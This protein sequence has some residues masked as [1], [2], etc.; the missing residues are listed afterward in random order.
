MEYNEWWISDFE[1]WWLWMGM[2][3]VFLIAEIL[4][5]GFFL[6]WFSF[7]AAAAGILA[8]MGIGPAAQIIIFVVTTGILFVFGR[9]FAESVTHQQPPGIGAD[10]FLEKE[11]L[12]IEDI[13]NHNNTGMI[14][15]GSD[16]WR[17]RSESGSII[18][19][20]IIVIV[21]KIDGA[22]AIVKTLEKE[23]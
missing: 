20:G 10:R 16:E 21:V 23:N 11:G 15:I 19:S 5:A 13:D 14:R 7:G 2:A 1:M 22:H 4:T 6:L 17:A 12:T 3:A 18:K 8:M 9:R